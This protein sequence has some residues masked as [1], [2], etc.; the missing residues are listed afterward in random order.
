MRVP[1]VQAAGVLQHDLSQG[2]VGVLRNW[3]LGQPRMHPCQGLI[4]P[5][6]VVDNTIGDCKTTSHGAQEGGPCTRDGGEPVTPDGHSPMQP[7][8]YL[9]TDSGEFSA[10]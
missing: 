4:Q 6:A 3:G 10:L 2:G 7:V 1:G 8:A 9:A 5:A